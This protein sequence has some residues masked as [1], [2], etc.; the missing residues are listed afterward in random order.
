MT[1][2]WDSGFMVHQPSWHRLEKA[3]L[4]ESPRSWDDA[5]KEADL[6]WDVDTYPVYRRRAE[7]IYVDECEHFIPSD[8]CDQC[9]TT[10]LEEAWSYE[11]IPGWKELRRDDNETALSVQPDT[12]EVIRNE[13]FGNVIDAALG[14]EDDERVEFEA[15]MSLYGGR[16]VVA[17][18][19]FPEKLKMPWDSS[20]TYAYCALTSR[21]DGSGGVRGIITNVRVQ[22]ANTLKLAEMVDGRRNGFTIR[23]TAN[24]KERLAEIR[25]QMVLARGEGQKWVE[26]SEQLALWKATPRRREDYLKR[27]FPISDDDGARK[28][29]N[30]QRNREM[31]RMILKSDS[32]RDIADNGYGLLMA[33]TEW[34]DHF[35]SSRTD[36]SLVAR[37][38]INAE[39]TKARAAGV[40]R[41]MAGIKI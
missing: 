39:P 7:T 16:Q 28:A 29:E 40:L 25:A 38:L 41:S 30:A 17:L 5:R 21:H 36:D 32:T 22:C 2:H 33:T 3:V 31:V 14:L 1:H 18:C 26:F 11:E 37:Q 13:R 19:Y 8:Q 6:I 4:K 34:S 15:L 12:Y 24:W 10:G 23:H 27:M 35:R 20:P 9:P